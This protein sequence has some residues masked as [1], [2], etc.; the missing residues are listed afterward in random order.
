VTAIVALIFIV[1]IVV[2]A[3]SSAG[4]GSGG[5]DTSGVGA[6]N[7]CIERTQLLVITRHE[8]G[9]GLVETISLRA[10][11]E[12]VGQFGAF[13]SVPAAVSFA[14]TL[15]VSG[16]GSIHGRMVLLTASPTG[17][18]ARAIQACGGPEFPGP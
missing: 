7:S 10:N 16:S 3:V 14:R 4:G 6:F 11:H 1:A 9:S 18:A 8:S 2:V 13:R 12:E 5:S 15:P 17:R